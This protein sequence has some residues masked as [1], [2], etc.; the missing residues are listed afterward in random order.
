[1]KSYGYICFFLLFAFDHCWGASNSLEVTGDSDS[2]AIY[3]LSLD[4]VTG[5]SEGAPFISV[6]S[7][8]DNLNEDTSSVTQE[9][10][11]D[12]LFTTSY[13]R[14]IGT[15]AESCPEGFDEVLGICAEICPTGYTAAIGACW[16]NCP[17]GWAD[18]GLFCAKWF[19]KFRG[20]D[21]FSQELIATTA[22]CEDG[23]D[24][25][26]G[27]CYE[28][29][30]DGFVGSGSLCVGDL[31]DENSYS[32]LSSQVSEQQQ[33]TA[34]RASTGGVEIPDDVAHEL[35]ATVVFAP[36]ACT[37]S[38]L[39]GTLGFLPDSVDFVNDTVNDA[40]EESIGDWAN[41]D[42]GSAW[43]IPTIANTVLFDLSAEAVCEDDGEVAQA[44]LTVNPSITVEVQSNIFDTALH[45]L[46]G[47]DL[48]I[49]SLSIYEL[50]PF[51][52]YGS[53]GATLSVPT[54]L[55]SVLDRSLP[56]LLIDGQQY[57]NKTALI[58]DPALELWLSTEAYLRV[59]SLFSF[60]PDL[61]Q[62]GVEF[63]LDVLDVEMPYVME[64][65]LR[66][67]TD[68]YE[69]YRE[70]SL[71]SDLSTGSGSVDSFLRILGVE[72][73]IFGD[74]GDITWEGYHRY[75]ELIY[76]ESSTDISI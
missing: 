11:E 7:T 28:P 32:A 50:I 74:S 42:L 24:L 30:D 68:G 58:V 31:N 27:R 10:L 34:A 3:P 48:G 64:Q 25:D 69:I 2:G 4:A 75:D 16:E 19:M 54:E 36:V 38:S 21:I 51:R 57:A 13:S 26:S 15:T 8:V 35:A 76:E 6:S 5:S 1:M 33:V 46:T 20:K 66:A 65:G 70:E 44:Y 9:E 41:P 49:M 55:Y 23:L 17:S 53:V 59:T 52:V 14:G 39:T 71:I 40:I 12:S 67:N 72:I 62:L 73:N 61:L 47:V 22:Y 29:C 45:D 37:I 63:N 43:Y 60:I 18:I 56:A